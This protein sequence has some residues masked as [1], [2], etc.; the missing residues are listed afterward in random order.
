MATENR[1]GKLRQ[2]PQRRIE[3]V[4]ATEKGKV[5]ALP[6]GIATDCPSFS[7]SSPL[8]K[9][10][11]KNCKMCEQEYSIAIRRRRRQ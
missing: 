7:A 2:G 3:K 11:N 5:F 4:S 9:S 10:L 6:L 1:Q 8:K